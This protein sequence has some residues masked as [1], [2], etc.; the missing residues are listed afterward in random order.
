MMTRPKLEPNHDV[1]QAA[2]VFVTELLATL[3]LPGDS[4]KGRTLLEALKKYATA[5]MNQA[6]SQ[7]GSDLDK[8]VH[9]H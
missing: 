5:V 7:A 2:D 6:Y 8:A 4:H 9:P 1:I 3:N